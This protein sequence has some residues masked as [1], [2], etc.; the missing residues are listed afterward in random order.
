LE[1]THGG[2]RVYTFE[3]SKK[4]LRYHFKQNGKDPFN[5]TCRN[6]GYLETK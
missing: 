5:V 4:L 1:S 2:E 3:D 6:G